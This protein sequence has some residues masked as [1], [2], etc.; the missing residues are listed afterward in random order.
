MRRLFLFPV[1]VRLPTVVV[2]SLLDGGIMTNQT[3]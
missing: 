3:Q 1:P 2:G